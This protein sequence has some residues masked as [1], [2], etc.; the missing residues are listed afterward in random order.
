[1]NTDEITND[2]IKR[3]LLG[4]RNPEPDESLEMRIF[5]EDTTDGTSEEGTF[6]ERLSASEDE[7]VDDYVWGD[8]DPE[9]GR[10]FREKF[11]CTPERH[12]KLAFATVLNEFL[13]STAVPEAPL[14]LGHYPETPHWLGWLPK[15]PAAQ[16]WSYA[17]A[18][19]V[20]FAVAGSA[21]MFAAKLQLE[22]RIGQMVAD[23][24]TLEDQIASLRETELRGA[25]ATSV[26]TFWLA[27]GLLRGPGEVERV[28]IPESSD[29]VRVQLDLGIDDYESY[30]VALHDASGDE[31]WTQSKLRAMATGETVAVTVILPSE[32]VPHGDYYFRLSGV[33]MSGDL[34]LVARYHF[35]ALGE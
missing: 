31:I 4:I 27:P 25:M 35:R 30:R 2:D 10:K 28:I 34:E 24:V 23:R 18:A 12:R 19:L 9:D 3:A 5:S 1:M 33:T 6:S 15:A 7:L 20:L 21:W 16:V 29:L 22:G 32:L 26:A 13:D 8:L 14:D 17:Q 11:L